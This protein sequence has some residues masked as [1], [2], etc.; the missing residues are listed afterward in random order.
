MVS[1]IILYIDVIDRAMS[2]DIVW[3]ETKQTQLINSVFHN[4]YI[5]PVIFAVH[6]D[7]EGEDVRVCVDGK[8]RL[9]SIQKFFD[10]Q[11]SSLTSTIWKDYIV[12]DIKDTL[13]V[14]HAKARAGCGH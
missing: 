7:D 9:T 13:Y 12:H 3:S 2:I 8:Q 11:V 14:R 6:K 4:F 5:P 1:F 10:G